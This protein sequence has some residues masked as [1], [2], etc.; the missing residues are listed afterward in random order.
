MT[1]SAGKNA[2]RQRI[3]RTPPNK[4]VEGLRTRGV[5]SSIQAAI[6]LKAKRDTMQVKLTFQQIT[7]FSTIT[8]VIHFTSLLL[9][10]QQRTLI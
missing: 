6:E 3:E 7:F 4:V 8:S 5:K 9:L 1:V 10:L 2:R